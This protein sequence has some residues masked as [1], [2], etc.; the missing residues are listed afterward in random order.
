MD[1]DPSCSFQVKVVAKNLVFG[2]L[3]TQSQAA[4]AV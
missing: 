4:F 1:S 2:S 3:G